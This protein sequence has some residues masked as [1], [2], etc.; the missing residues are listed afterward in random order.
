MNYVILF[1]GAVG[2][3]IGP[4]H[5][6]FHVRH[7]RLTVRGKKCSQDKNNNSAESTRVLKDASN[8]QN[9][10]DMCCY[11]W[12]ALEEAVKADVQSVKHGTAWRIL[13]PCGSSDFIA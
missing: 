7:T 13:F 9:Q 12:L 3:D 8:R 4:Q 11:V 10:I 5:A 2:G 1:V 6:L